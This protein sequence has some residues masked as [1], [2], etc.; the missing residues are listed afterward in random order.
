M[1]QSNFSTGVYSWI[2]PQSF[3]IFCAG[4][5]VSYGQYTAAYNAKAMLPF[6]SGSSSEISYLPET[7]DDIT[8]FSNGTLED[9]IP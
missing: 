8:N 5:D 9:A 2:N 1:R 4:L 7:Y 6:P 3:Q